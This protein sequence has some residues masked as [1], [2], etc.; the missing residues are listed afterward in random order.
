MKRYVVCLGVCDGR[1]LT[2]MKTTGPHGSRG[3]NGPGGEVMEGESPEDAASREW[4]EEVRGSTQVGRRWRMVGHTNGPGW[5]VYFMWCAVTF[6]PVA[7]LV[8]GSPATFLDP[9]RAGHWQ[10]E[11]AHDFIAMAHLAVVKCAAG[12][13]RC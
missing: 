5:E 3:L 13:H 2:H 10:R 8:D 1:A 7:L 4:R 12:F 9:N 6:D 11:A